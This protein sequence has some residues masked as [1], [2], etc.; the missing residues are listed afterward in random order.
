[1]VQILLRVLH[2]AGWRLKWAG[3]RWME[4]GGGWNG[5]DG[6]GWSWVEVGARFSNTRFEH[7]EHFNISHFPYHLRYNW[8]WLK[9]ANNFLTNYTKL[10]YVKFKWTNQSCSPSK[11]GQSMMNGAFVIEMGNNSFSESKKNFGRLRKRGTF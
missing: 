7:A 11:I 9:A 3:W 2:R 8:L 10:C 6:G 1:M 5:L 4:M